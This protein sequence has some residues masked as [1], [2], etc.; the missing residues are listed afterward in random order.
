M[1]NLSLEALHDIVEIALDR[2]V[3]EL[4]PDVN[5]YTDIGMDSFGAVAM[6]VEIQR[7]YSVRIPDGEI[8]NLQTP[9][10]VIVYVNKQHI[11]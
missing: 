6:V 2:E 7:K 5:L 11:R 10:A 8:A 1:P 3:P 4:T 9:E